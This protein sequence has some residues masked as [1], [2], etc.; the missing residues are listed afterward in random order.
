M[1]S[2]MV[3]KKT[4]TAKCRR[5]GHLACCKK[6]NKLERNNYVDIHNK[7]TLSFKITAGVYE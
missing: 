4:Q 7:Q 2:K 1:T 3:L 6:E 5:K